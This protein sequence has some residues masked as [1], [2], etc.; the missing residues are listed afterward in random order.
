MAFQSSICEHSHHLF[1]LL[2]SGRH[3]LAPKSSEQKHACDHEN[4]NNFFKS[5]DYENG[6]KNINWSFA[7]PL[8]LGQL[9]IF[10]PDFP[11]EKSG[12]INGKKWWADG[13]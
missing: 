13:C 7:V 11:E 12:N 9:I 6:T 5:I 3:V 10:K 8:L 2:S 4:S 1:F